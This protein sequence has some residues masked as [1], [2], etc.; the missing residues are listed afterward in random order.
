MLNLA[1][2]SLKHTG[3]GGAE[4]NT[5]PYGRSASA[6]FTQTRQADLVCQTRS[7]A[8]APASC[9]RASRV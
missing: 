4:A 2:D 8:H 5:P 7:P 1:P 3:K 9:V 6:V